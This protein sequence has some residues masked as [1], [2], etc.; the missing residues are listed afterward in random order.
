MSK[1]SELSKNRLLLVRSVSTVQMFDY[2]WYK[3]IKKYRKNS[4]KESP[5]MKPYFPKDM[6][7]YGTSWPER[8]RLFSRFDYANISGEFLAVNLD[9][10]T[11]VIGENINPKS[12]LKELKREKE[13]GFPYTHVGFSVFIINYSEF[14]KCAKVIKDFDRSITVIAGNVGAM[15]DET[16]NHADLVCKVDGV[17]YLRNLFGEDMNKPY[18]SKLVT[19]ETE[20]KAFGLKIKSPS[21]MLVTKLGC[22]LNC[23]FC[24]TAKIFQGKTVPTFLTPKQVLE[25]LIEYQNKIKGDTFNVFLCEPS[26]IVSKD[27][28]YELFEMFE[29]EV[30]DI[31]IVVPAT[32]LSLKKF[33]FKRTHDSALR[34]SVVNVGVESLS[35]DYSKNQGHEET[36]KILQKLTDNGIISYGTF[37]IGFDH[38]TPENV[39]EEVGELTKLGLTSCS[40]L[41]L[42]PLPSTPIWDKLKKEKRLLDLPMKYYYTEAFQAFKHDHFRPGFIDMLPLNFETMK[43]FEKECGYTFLNLIELYD[44]LAKIK[45]QPKFLT[46]MNTMK[47]ISKLLLPSWKKKL[48]PTPEQEIKYIEKLGEVPKIPAYMKLLAKNDLFGKIIN[49]FIHSVM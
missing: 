10:P 33:D 8:P 2:N 29:G 42:K 7:K 9:V 22:S 37:I 48:N 30:G 24:I 1:Q 35:Q 45:S 6:I 15:F 44:N 11:T 26:G 34:F 4:L 27:W 19:S 43:Y 40:I 3:G 25:M 21:S 32:L 41:N 47:I 28:W 16:D 23:D 31:S 18:K 20:F 46:S 36:K 17:P 38:H 12:L 5:D 13:R 39:W 14:V 49:P